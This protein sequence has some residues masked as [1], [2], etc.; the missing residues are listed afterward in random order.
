MALFSIRAHSALE[1]AA[2]A[3]GV[4]L[5]F[6]LASWGFWINSQRQA[7]RLNA[8]FGI[9]DTEHRLSESDRAQIQDA[10]TTLR[11][12]YGLE[13]RVSITLLEPVLP[14][15]DEPTKTLFIGLS[16]ATGKA[17][18]V[19]PPLVEKAL[20]P[21]L[22]PQLMNELLPFHMGPGKHW[23]KGL[24]L[25]LEQIQSSLAQPSTPAAAPA[26]PVTAAQP[27]PAANGKDTVHK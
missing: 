11:T 23:Q 27:A 18:V 2:R 19:F 17:L 9:S 13:L 15:M 25:A 16:P 12:K 1:H 7:D 22:A 14:P 8:R 3:V 5:V 6:A 4:L 20:G 26:T 21:D 24:Q 10:I